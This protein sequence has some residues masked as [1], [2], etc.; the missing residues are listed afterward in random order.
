MVIAAAGAAAMVGG[1]AM[2]QERAVRASHA[3]IVTGDLRSAE[4]MLVA[5]RRIFPKRA[6][7][8]LNLAAVYARSNRT[9]E[10]AALYDQ[11][12]AGDDAL[13]DV[14]EG[15]TLSAHSVARL[16]KSKLRNEIA[17]R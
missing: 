4:Q 17:A 6:E 2:A 8:L 15:R 3:A 16:G 10:A 13:M 7:L 12:L 14:A 1:P 11:V 5:E 9:G